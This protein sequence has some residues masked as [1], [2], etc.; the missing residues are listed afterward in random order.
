MANPDFLAALV[1]LVT[2]LAI[3]GGA[4][5]FRSYRDAAHRLERDRLASLTRRANDGGRF[6]GGCNRPGEN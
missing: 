3:I 5:L 2:F 4:A 1:G 6:I